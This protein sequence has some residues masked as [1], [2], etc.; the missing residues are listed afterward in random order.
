MVKTHQAV[1]FKNPFRHNNILQKESVRRAV[2]FYMLKSCLIF[3]LR[4][5]SWICTLACAFNDM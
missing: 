2:S 5:V 3:G 1:I 4:E